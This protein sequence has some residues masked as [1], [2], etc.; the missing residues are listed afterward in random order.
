MRRPLGYFG[1]TA[2]RFDMLWCIF[3]LDGDDDATPAFQS[4]VRKKL[5]VTAATVT[6]MMQ[7]LEALGLVRRKRDSFDRRQVLVSLT[8]EGLDRL[9]A[10][11][12]QFVERKVAEQAIA[13][14]LQDDQPPGQRPADEQTASCA[15]QR[16][17]ELLDRMRAGF[18]DRAKLHY[19]RRR[20]ESWP[21]ELE[22]EV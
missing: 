15:M 12:A 1:L 14:A 2:A 4:D 3:Q 18:G 5:G 9:R 19:G 17:G 21:D 20:D 16:F 10:A 8:R 13:N 11:Y 6:R 22:P 7:S